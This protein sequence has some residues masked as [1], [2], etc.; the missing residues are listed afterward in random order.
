MGSCKLYLSPRCLC[1]GIAKTIKQKR[2]GLI[3]KDV[4]M[5]CSRNGIVVV[6]AFFGSATIILG[7][8]ML[9]VFPL[10]ADLSPGFRTP[11]I[12]FEFARTEA[13]L[14]FLAGSSE[15]SVLNRAKMDAGLDW[16]MLFPFAY[17]GFIAFLALQQV[18]SGR[19]I[20]WVGVMSAVLII[21]FDL[22]ENFVLLAISSALAE[23][24]SIQA[25]LLEL[26]VAT[27][28]KWSAIGV[29]V[30]VLAFGFMARREYFPAGISL[31]AAMG[32]VVCW[33]TDSDAV[34]AEAMSVLLFLF[35]I[36]LSLRS[37]GQS[38]AL[39]RRRVE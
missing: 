17:A 30:T 16:D 36:S 27:W 2:R 13:D 26:H 34:A 33:L 1:Y 38:W 31:L 28:L 8:V 5:L 6:S 19:P 21:P 25:L 32:L 4:E 15:I 3:A 22:Q 23:S 11:I 14:A 18:C 29:S 24:A 7:I 20:A 35:F 39:I 12:A 37:C 9:F 10:S